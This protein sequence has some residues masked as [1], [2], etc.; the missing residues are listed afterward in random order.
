MLMRLNNWT[1]HSHS[2]I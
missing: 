2:I 1:I